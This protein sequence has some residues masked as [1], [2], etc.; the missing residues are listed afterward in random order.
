MDIFSARQTKLGKYL[1]CNRN[2]LIFI[3]STNINPLRFNYCLHN[4]IIIKKY[5]G[6]M[7]RNV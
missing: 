6:H 5:M 1:F 3:K 7:A 2:I 4:N